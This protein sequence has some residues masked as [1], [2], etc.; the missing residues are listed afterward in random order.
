[1]GVTDEDGVQRKNIFI[2]SHSMGGAY[3][4]GIVRYLVAN[5]L[6]VDSVMHFSAADNKDFSV[7]LPAVTYQINIVP[8]PGADVQEPTRPHNRACRKPVESIKER[9]SGAGQREKPDA[10]QIA[11]MLRNHYIEHD[12][13]MD[14]L[15]HY[16]TKASKVWKVVPFL[17]D[18][19][20]IRA[21]S[22]I[23][24]RRSAGD[25]FGRVCN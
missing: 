10:Y 12:G 20:D 14:L 8:R 19:E 7:G 3:A 15:N 9:I 13:G 22:E 21:L 11:N 16:Y 1:M 18:S 17:N 4:E 23:H 5:G 6:K 2:V 24:D 25:G